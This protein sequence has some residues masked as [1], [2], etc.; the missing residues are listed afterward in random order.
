MPLPIAAT[1]NGGFG[2]YA[3]GAQTLGSGIMPSRGTTTTYGYV[4]YYEAE[5]F[6][7]G[8]GRSMVPDFHL[9]V[10]AEGTMTRHTWDFQYGGMRFGSA[11]IQE[12]V[13][14][15]I[16]AGGASESDHDVVL[17]NIQP[18]A[19]SRA[20]GAWHLLT[21]SHLLFP[22]GSYDEAA[23]ANAENNYFA[24]AQ[25][26]SATWVPNRQW[27]VDL[28]TN[29]TLNKRNKK[30]DYKSGDLIGL[31]WAVNHNPFRAAPQ[32]Q[33][34]V[35]GLYLRQ[36]EDD[37]LHDQRAGDGFRIHKTSA[38]PQI[39][40]WFSPAVAVVVKWQKEWNVRN[41]PQGDAFWLQAAFPL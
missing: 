21:A 41:A 11:V 16:D 4:L 29:L 33:F 19:V 7:D 23:L 3:I 38:G 15:G 8:R 20:F 40:Y 24:F 37:Q 28:S 12:A 25:E 34:G 31:T 14:V 10:S 39:A 13:R 18:L 6:V 17:L 27:M 5:N 2:P 36:I 26:F 30:S 1:E 35:N 32:W 9:T 22:L